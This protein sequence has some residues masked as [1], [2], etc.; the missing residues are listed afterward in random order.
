M[1]ETH[2]HTRASPSSSSVTSEESVEAHRSWTGQK[3][4][5]LLSLGA[6]GSLAQRSSQEGRVRGNN[7][8]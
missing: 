8:V 3:Q 4:Q 7:Q 2:M 5:D 1:T 6:W